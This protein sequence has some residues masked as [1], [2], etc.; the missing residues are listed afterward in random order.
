MT[1][2][3]YGL[4]F[5]ILS[6]F[7][8][9]SKDK[10]TK[11][12]AII[13]LGSLI[14]YQLG[15]RDYLHSSND[16]YNYFHHY[17]ALKDYSWNEILSSFQLV[18]S[19]Y[20]ERDPGYA[21]FVKLTQI[22]SDDFRFYLIILAVIITVPFCILMNKFIP[23]ASGVYLCGI[24]FESLFAPFF[25]TGLRQMIA[26]GIIYA[27][28][29]FIFKNRIKYHY[30]LL[31]LA[32]TI[33]SSSLI[34][35]PVYV[36]MKYFNN[37]RKL[38]ILSIA[39]LPVFMIFASSIISFIGE[40]TIFETYAVNSK[41][42][43]GTPVF[44]AM[45]VLIVITVAVFSKY[46]IEDYSQYNNFLLVTLVFSCCLIPSTWVNSNFIRIV[47]TFLIFICAII[48]MIIECIHKNS[49]LPIDRLGMYFFVG[50]GLLLLMY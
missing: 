48:P 27:S 45:V 19:E 46:F 15:F 18:A 50:V 32:Y 26:M 33:H 49:L 36:I 13:I 8:M 12:Q 17:V 47:F 25:M 24:I 14:I 30:L 39:L 41:D 10:Q 23:T 34:F 5:F 4:L 22:I 20:V 9:N 43:L 6:L 21:I 40:G 35:I 3:S 7:F 29:P 44:T 31:L 16:T 42:N 28:V 37:P 2:F 38:L 1:P 11:R